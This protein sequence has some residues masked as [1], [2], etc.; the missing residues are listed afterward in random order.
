MANITIKDFDL[1]APFWEQIRDGDS[2]IL[3]N[4]TEWPQAVWNLIL[5]KRDVSIYADTQGKMKI[6]RSWKI[7]NVKKY[8]G[9]KGNRDRVRDLICWLVDYVKSEATKKKEKA[10]ENE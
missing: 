8:F 5:T 6:T 10:N 7:S 3:V 9:V 1:T 2:K 4:G